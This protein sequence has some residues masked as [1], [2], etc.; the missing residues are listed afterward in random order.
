MSRQKPKRHRELD[1]H[2][3]PGGGN[4]VTVVKHNK[5]KD[6]TKKKHFESA[7]LAASQK[8]DLSAPIRLAS[9]APVEMPDRP[10]HH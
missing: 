1:T 9:R 5:D 6:A 2:P 4:H 3:F 7:A 8:I 10:G